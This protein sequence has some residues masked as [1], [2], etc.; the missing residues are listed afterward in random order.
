MKSIIPSLTVADIEASVRFYADVLG[1]SVQMTMPGQDGMLAYASLGRGASSVMF[2]R[3]D[4]AN[5]HDQAPLGRGVIL[6]ATVGD[7]E[8]IDA[9]FAHAKAAGARVTQEPTDEF[10]GMRDWGIADPDGYVWMVSKETG[11]PS[12]AEMR[13]GMLAGS[14]A[15]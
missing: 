1:F 15:D 11:R 13:D 14:P 7:E 5:A 12:E 2:G 6:Y 10:W 9:L 3:I 4:P 8:D